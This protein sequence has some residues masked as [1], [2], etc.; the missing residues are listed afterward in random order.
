[1]NSYRVS[2]RGRVDAARSVSFTFDGKTYRG[3]KGDTVASALLANGVHLMGRS[4]KYHRP[5]GPVAAGSEE[6]NA[7]IGTRRSAGRFEPN[8]RATVQEIWNGLETTSQNKYPSLKFDIGAVNDMAYMLFSAGFYYKTFMWP[9]S[10][11]NKVY[12]PFIRAAAGLGVSPTEEDPDTYASRNLHCDVLIVGAG[13][14]GLAAAR[15]A[16]VDGLKVV[17]VDENAEAGGTLLSEPQA[18]IDGKPAWNWLADELKALKERG[19]RV[20][21]RTTAI[22]YYHQNMIGLCE[23]LTDHLETVPKDTPRERLW[24]VRA[25]QVV[26]AQG[27][28]EKPLV[29]HGNDRP[30]VMLAGAAQTYLNRYGV[31]V[32]NRPV[33]VTSHDSAWYA[34]FDLQGAGARVQAIVDT[35][36]KVREEL[37]NEA[38]ALG[39][40]V[41]LS[42]TVT[43]TSGRLRVKSVRVNAVS[44]ASVGA[45]QEVACDAV[46]MSG[47]WTPSLH[48]F[49]HTQGK[50]AWDDERTTFLPAL[51]NEDCVIAGAGLGLWGIEVALKDGAER[52][53]E[54]AAALGKVANSSSHAVEHDRTGSG[55]SHTELPSDRDAGKAKA[56]VDYQNDVT[57]KDL[58]LAVREGMRSIEH[59]KR[60]TTNGMAT[61]QGK[62]SNINGLNIAAEALG[63]RQPQVGL[64]TFRPPYTPTTFGAFAGYH[65]GAHFEVTRKTQIDGWAEEHGAVYEPVGQWRRAWYFPKPGEDMDAAVSRECRAVRQS[66]GIFDASTLGKIEVVGPD[67]VEFMNRMYTNPWTKLA[68]GRCRYGLLLGDDGFIRD[69]GVIG[70]MTEDRF[71]VTTTTGGAARVLNMMEDYLQTEWPDLNVWLTS[72]TEQWST[73]ALNGP[74]A[75]KLLAPLVEGVELTEEAFPHMSCVECTVAG[76]P[77][78]LFRVSFTG[79]IGFE[80]NVPAPLGRKLWEILWDAG[81]QYG[82]TPYGTETMHVLRAEKGY[83]IVGQDTDGTVTPYDA[84]MG[85]AV[86]K[87]KP[88]F[89]GK[90]GLARPDLVAKGRRHLVGLLTEDRSKLEEGAQIVFDPKQPI[91]MKMVGHVTSSYHSDAVGQP[92][93]L[94]LVEGGHERMGETVY[95]PMLDRTIATKITGMVFVDPENTRLKI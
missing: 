87:N 75:A 71:H 74:N 33:V 83:I 69:D 19:V 28:L 1:M 86:G 92:I 47:G 21:T 20:M 93:A 56:F 73:I 55:V 67:A 15:A 40:P 53:R 49:S 91:P 13:P 16:A 63:K 88:D 42:H 58:R 61:D 22:A 80:V 10:F 18:K 70:R 94:A 50:I 6:P 9:K 57:A 81:Q 89:V 27:A 4:F 68:A 7:L 37:V 54:V 39:I 46:L 60:Y 59:V 34:A 3:V 17:L 95:I 72:T 79:E 32:G 48:L 66:V 90:R 77:A 65:R 84:A 44:G 12:E 26:L 11:W 14:A 5:R 62:M 76:M 36:A 25:R 51:T 35:R 85:W 29:F 30:G 82:I 2:G 24:R 64:T 45:G 78:R 8:T 41:K 52:G 23:K 38:R 43:A 31:K